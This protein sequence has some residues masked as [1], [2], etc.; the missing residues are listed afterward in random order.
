MSFN[1]ASLLAQLMQLPVPEQYVVAYS[2]GVDSHVLLHALSQMRSALPCSDLR[3]IHINHGIHPDAA[4]WARHCEGICRDLDVAFTT[5]TIQVERQA[6]YSFEATARDARYDALAGEINANDMLLLAHHQDDQAETLLLQLLRGSGVKGLAGM[7]RCTHF[8]QGWMAR[9]LLEFTREEL[10]QYAITQQLVWI[11]DPS[12]RDT[13]FDRN[14][15]RHAVLPILRQRWPSLDATLSRVAQHQADADALLEIMARQD[16]ALLTTSEFTV[17]NIEPFNVLQATRQRNVLRYWLHRICG[18]PLPSSVQ[19]QRIISEVVPAADDATPLVHWPGAEVRRY[20]NELYAMPPLTLIDSDWCQQ[21]DLTNSICLPT[22]DELQVQHGEG[23]GLSRSA[24]KQGVTI[25][26]R[27]GGER[28]RL[29]G[30]SHD[31]ELKKL[32]QDWAVPPWQ[33]DRV[34]LIYIGEQ[35]A[36]VV[37]FCV[38]TPFVAKP[39]EAGMEI[40]AKPPQPTI[41]T[42]AENKDNSPGCTH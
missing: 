2:G 38:C 10:Q 28:C 31:H 1:S 32:F 14:F 29:P 21:W 40:I 33:R 3:A 24:L 27:R 30:R 13:T 22:G 6:T 5:H 15:L 12:N 8:S 42:M 23:V 41:E 19:L 37:G 9:P 4:Q 34:P 39:N 35:L 17:I 11:E 26:Y 16:L 18:L 25:R 36:Q 7:P 20:R